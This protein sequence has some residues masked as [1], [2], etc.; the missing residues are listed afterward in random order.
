MHGSGLSR[1][2]HDLQCRFGNTS[3]AHYNATPQTWYGNSVVRATYGGGLVRCVTP[4]S[5][6]SGAARRLRCLRAGALEYDDHQWGGRGGDSTWRAT[7]LDSDHHPSWSRGALRLTSAG[8]GEMG[9]VGVA[10]IDGDRPISTFRASFSLSMSGGSCG[11][12]GLSMHCGAEG[13]SFVY[14]LLPEKA[15][16]R[17]TFGQA[18]ASRCSQAASRVLLSHTS[19][20][21]RQLQRSCHPRG[22]CAVVISTT[23]VG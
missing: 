8:Y 17:L 6:Q 19:R 20:C 1:Q 15:L 10:A 4:T 5:A 23:R 21:F 12:A 16:E 18:C 7:V 13:V 11:H 2:W 9:S 22:L 14:G 3:S